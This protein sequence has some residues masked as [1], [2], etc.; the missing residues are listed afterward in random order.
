MKLVTAYPP[1]RFLRFKSYPFGVVNEAIRNKTHFKM[2]RD[3][4]PP[5]ADSFRLYVEDNTQVPGL[6]NFIKKYYAKVGI[7]WQPYRLTTDRHMHT[8][9]EAAGTDL[10]N[11]TLFSFSD[12]DEFDVKEINLEDLESKKKPRNHTEKGTHHTRN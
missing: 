1:G 10:E 4:K 2:F 6:L 12:E 5:N 7:F 9:T 8:M 3:D 11:I